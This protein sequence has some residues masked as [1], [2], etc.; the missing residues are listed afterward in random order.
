MET[1][2]STTF[3]SG[4]LVKAGTIIGGLHPHALDGHIL[5]II[6]IDMLDSDY[7][8]RGRV[9]TKDGATQTVRFTGPS[10]PQDDD[11]DNV[12]SYLSV[13]AKAL[14]EDLVVTVDNLS[15]LRVKGETSMEIISNKFFDEAEKRDWCA[16]AFKFIH[17]INSELPLP[18]N[19]PLR[20]REFEVEV[21]VTGTISVH[22]TATVKARSQEEAEDNMRDCPDD[23][24]DPEEILRDENLRYIS[25]DNIEVEVE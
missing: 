20:E 2:I 14:R 10:I 7:P 24:F 17:E 9:Y 3:V 4:D 21:T 5:R 23:Y 18:F 13:E 22:H 1:G 16:E 6:S 8:Y 11:K 15:T 25:I 12:I 19:I